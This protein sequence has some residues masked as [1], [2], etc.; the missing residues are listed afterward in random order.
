MYIKPYTT[1]DAPW[2]SIGHSPIENFLL[3]LGFFRW[4]IVKPGYRTIEVAGGF[5][6]NSM[7]FTLDLGGSVPGDM[8][9]VPAGDFQWRSLN[10]AYLDDFW[11]DR[12]E[13]TNRQFKEF[14]DQG[15]YTKRQYWSEEFVENGRVLSWEQAMAKFRDATG[16]PG[17]STWE[18]GAYPSGQDDF[19]VNGVSWY[20]AAAYAEFAKKQLP[21]IY[22]WYRAASPGIY[23]E[24]LLF[25]NFDSGGP[26]RVGSHGGPWSVRNLRH[27]RQRTGVVLQCEWPPPL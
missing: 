9:H 20:E 2:M 1:P 22:H 15:G 5:Q 14:I 19:P 23:S 16:R 12:Y 6:L 13:V 10:T 26:V 4:R 18:V 21:T 24:I 11:I 27:G 25:S 17:P 7:E 3:P 8:V